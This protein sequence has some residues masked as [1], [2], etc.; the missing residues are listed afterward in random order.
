VKVYV[1]NLPFSATGEELSALFQK[2]GEVTS[3]TIVMDR[4]TGRSRGFGFVEM[5]DDDGARKAIEALNNFDMGGRPLRVNEARPREEGDGGRGG[6][7]R[8]PRG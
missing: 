3:A 1:G 6:G 4:Q 7:R 8:P 2:Y 5:S